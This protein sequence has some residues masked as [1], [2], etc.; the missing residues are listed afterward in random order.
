VRYGVLLWLKSVLAMALVGVLVCVGLLF[1]GTALSNLDGE[2]TF[3]L[4]SSSS[5]AS[6]KSKLELLDLPFVTGESVMI[7]VKGTDALLG[8]VLETYGATLQFMEEVDGIRSYYCYSPCLARKIFL[9][10]RAVNLHIAVRGDDGVAVVGTPIIFG[11][12]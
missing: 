12:F 4:H 1:K 10:G 11:G 7:S 9:Q 6:Q 2:R 5:W 8:N 3:Y